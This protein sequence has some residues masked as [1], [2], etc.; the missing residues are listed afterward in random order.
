MNQQER[1]KIINNISK[2]KEILF[3]EKALK[4]ALTK[5]ENQKDTIIKALG[6]SNDIDLIIT[7][8][9]YLNSMGGYLRFINGLDKMSKEEI[10]R[11]K[12]TTQVVAVIARYFNKEN[13]LRAQYSREVKKFEKEYNRRYNSKR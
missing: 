9:Q 6:F 3:K 8:I 11:T 12:G 4:D 5:W 2:I 1:A 10:I 13:E 7:Y